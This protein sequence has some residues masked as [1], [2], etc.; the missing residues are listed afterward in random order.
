MALSDR[1][2][3]KH[4]GKGNIVISP[5][6]RHNLQTS[7]YDVCLGEWFYRE[8]QQPFKVFNIWSEN[9]TRKVWG[10]PQKAGLAKDVLGEIEP[11]FEYGQGLNENDRIILIAP[12]ETLLGHTIEFIGG[13]NIITT[14]MKA[15][16]TMGRDFIGV[17]KCAGWGDVGFINRWTMEITNFSRYYHI[18]LIVGERIAQIPFSKTGRIL[19]RS[20]S[21]SGKYQSG[22]DLATLKA[23]WSPEMMLPKLYK[24]RKARRQ[25]K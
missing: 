2:I 23:T 25:K 12:G 7:S 1:K 14:M 3:L 10:K 20:Y 6:E 16:S 19:N 22:S 13:L 24:D 8:T 17:C 4:M 5:F 9:H 18:P 21:D 11:D 15:R